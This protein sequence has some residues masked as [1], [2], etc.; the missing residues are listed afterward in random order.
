MLRNEYY[1]VRNELL[2]SASRLL[3]RP[4]SFLRS[5]FLVLALPICGGPVRPIIT[6]SADDIKGRNLYRIAYGGRS[7]AG[8]GP[9]YGGASASVGVT[10]PDVIRMGTS[11]SRLFP[12]PEKLT[13][14]RRKYCDDPNTFE[15]ILIKV[16]L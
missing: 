11:A 2:V 8:G 13:L 12:I 7:R 6:L 14:S 10:I 16:S 3:V 4:R 1:N 9:S 5:S 15:F